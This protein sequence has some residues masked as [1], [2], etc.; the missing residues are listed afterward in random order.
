MR[1]RLWKSLLLCALLLVA[2]TA[3]WAYVVCTDVVNVY[4]DGRTTKCKECE[5]YSNVDGSYQGEISSCSP[6]GGAV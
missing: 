1:G 6:G 3:I 2:P 5:I 4:P